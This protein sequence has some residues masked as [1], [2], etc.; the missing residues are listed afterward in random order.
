MVHGHG[1]KTLLQRDLSHSPCG[2]KCGCDIWLLMRS[3][4]VA[5]QRLTQMP[6]SSRQT[7]IKLSIEE[8]FDSAGR[9]MSSLSHRSRRRIRDSLISIID[10]GR[11]VDASNETQRRFP[12]RLA[13][14]PG[15]RIQL[16]LFLGITIG[17]YVTWP[18]I[19][20][21]VSCQ[22]G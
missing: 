5:D 21:T 20:Y 1:S 15:I 2:P 7:P 10:N 4:F 11:N 12:V 22:C 14:K 17:Q 3:C 16:R 18:I 8:T 13:P 9:S 6:L 19:V